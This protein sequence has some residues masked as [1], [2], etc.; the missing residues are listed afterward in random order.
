MRRNCVVQGGTENG[1]AFLTEI[2]EK[3]PCHEVDTVLDNFRTYSSLDY[4][5][6][7]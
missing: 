6:L 5:L 7:Q 3:G 1:R 2:G 4:F